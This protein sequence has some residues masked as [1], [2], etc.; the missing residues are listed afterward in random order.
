MERRSF[1]KLLGVAGAGSAL[2][3]TALSLRARGTASAKGSYSAARIVNEYSAFL[4]GERE[5]LAQGPAIVEASS[6]GVRLRGGAASHLLPV[7]EAV[8]GWRLVTVLH[9]NGIATAVFEKHVT[10]RERSRM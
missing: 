8:D 5:A 4:P 7:G 1:L 10:H 9:M 6:L 2:E 3:V